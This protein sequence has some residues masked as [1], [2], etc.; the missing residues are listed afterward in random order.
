MMQLNL[1]LGHVNVLCYRAFGGLGVQF[2]Y[3]KNNGKAV[4]GTIDLMEAFAKAMAVAN[5]K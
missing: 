4:L 3:Q 5:A 1:Q 2:L